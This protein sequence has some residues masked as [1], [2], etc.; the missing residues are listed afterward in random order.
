MKPGH[1]IPKIQGLCNCSGSTVCLC[2]RISL[3]VV[4]IVWLC[5]R[6]DIIAANK[7]QRNCGSIVLLKDNFT[8]TRRCTTNTQMLESLR[9]LVNKTYRSNMSKSLEWPG[10]REQIKCAL[11]LTS[12]RPCYTPTHAHMHTVYSDDNTPTD[13]WD[14]WQLPEL[15]VATS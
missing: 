6:V 9:P 4:E 3:Y 14:K 7:I 5:N 13:Q 2:V 15:K 11:S 1:S 12:V 8:C 10:N